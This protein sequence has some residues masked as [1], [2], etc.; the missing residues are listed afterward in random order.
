[1]FNEEILE[2]SGKRKNGIF[3]SEKYFP[4]ETFFLFFGGGGVRGGRG[5]GG[6]KFPS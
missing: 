1:M 6:Q 2:I 5:G 3:P 4:N